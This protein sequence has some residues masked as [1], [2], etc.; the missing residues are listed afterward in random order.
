M[1]TYEQKLRT[2][3]VQAQADFVIVA[4]QG[5][6]QGKAGQWLVSTVYG[7][8]VLPTLELAKGIRPTEY[9][10]QEEARLQKA[11]KSGRY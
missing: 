8:A 9:E 7:L 11:L 3:A 4:D 10:Q 1:P 2:V 5:K 6:L